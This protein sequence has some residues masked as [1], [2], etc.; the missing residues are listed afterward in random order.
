[1]RPDSW[2]VNTSR[3]PL[4]DEAALVEALQRRRIAGAALDVFDSEPLLSR[5]PAA[6]TRQCRGH[7][8]H[9]LCHRG[10]LPRLLPRYSAPDRGVARY[11][12]FVAPISQ[13]GVGPVR[14]SLHSLGY[15]SDQYPA[16]QSQT[17]PPSLW[18]AAAWPQKEWHMLPGHRGG[19]WVGE[20]HP[21]R[22][23]VGGAIPRRDVAPV[24]DAGD[25]PICH[26]HIARV[27]VAVQPVLAAH[28][29]ARP[30]PRS[31]YARSAV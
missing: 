27:Q 26:Q 3:G 17:S 29:S 16:I 22:R 12:H 9:R 1:M 30:T 24:D 8:A 2:L 19:M 28:R 6:H 14:R 7:R 10:Q 4:V 18:L 25:N 5:A 31:R 13:R 15:R 20:E 11:A 21:D 23:K